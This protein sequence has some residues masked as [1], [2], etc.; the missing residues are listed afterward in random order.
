MSVAPVLVDLIEKMA[1]AAESR[2][3]PVSDIQPD[4]VTSSQH[5]SSHTNR[6][7]AFTRLVVKIQ[8]IIA[9][10]YISEMFLTSTCVREIT[11]KKQT[12]PIFLEDTCVLLKSPVLLSFYDKASLFTHVVCWH[13]YAGEA[14]RFNAMFKAIHR[15]VLQHIKEDMFRAKA[16]HETVVDKIDKDRMRF[17]V[18]VLEELIQ[19]DEIR[20]EIEKTREELCDLV[21]RIRFHGF[22]PSTIESKEH[23]D[24]WNLCKNA[25]I[26]EAVEDTD[27]I[28]SCP[29]LKNE[30]DENELPA[31][32]HFVKL[33]SHPD[34]ISDPFVLSN[35]YMSLQ[36][37]TR[38][39]DDQDSDY[40]ASDTSDVVYPLTVV[41]HAPEDELFSSSSVAEPPPLNGEVD[42]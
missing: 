41:G 7:E 32:V 27:I 37:L 3:V 9:S 2:D 35:F 31:L 1:A 17:A 19:S 12:P 13:A 42:L 39:Y 29:R 28:L 36:D 40:N 18:R 15:V 5:G 26:T 10:K 14:A 4:T 22:N 8:Q 24:V 33:I 16:L 38:R 6:Y 11:E 30:I 21:I 20:Q 25:G 23:L 34:Y